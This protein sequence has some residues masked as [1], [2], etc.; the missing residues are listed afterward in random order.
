MLTTPER[1]SSHCKCSI[2]MNYLV[3][4]SCGPMGEHLVDPQTEAGNM[5]FV[6][7]R[8]G[9]STHSLNNNCLFPGCCSST[10]RQEALAEQ[11]GC[12]FARNQDKQFKSETD[13]LLPCREHLIL[14]EKSGKN[15]LRRTLCCLPSRRYCRELSFI[16]TEASYLD[17]RCNKIC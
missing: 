2:P 7:E 3:L 10:G 13:L 16:I 4:G 15:I 17:Q 14:I 11:H 6:G 5:E 8:A 12:V 1:R 9:K